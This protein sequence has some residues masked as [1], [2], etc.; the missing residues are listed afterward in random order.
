MTDE[1]ERRN[2]I[3]LGP[4]HEV[5]CEISGMEVVHVVG[6]SAGGTGMRVI[7]DKALPEADAFDLTMDLGDDQA[8]VRC[9][10][11]VVWHETKD[12]DFC[13]RHISGVAFADLKDTDRKRLVSLLPK[14]EA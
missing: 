14:A 6:L 10:A 11:R 8:A 7:T 5:R 13:N 1:P 12:F 9:R 2:Y 4:D 3:R